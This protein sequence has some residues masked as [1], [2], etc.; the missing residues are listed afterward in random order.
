[1][2]YQPLMSTLKPVLMWWGEKK[3]V[4]QCA[5]DCFLPKKKIKIA[6]IEQKKSMWTQLI[7]FGLVILQ[8]IAKFFSVRINGLQKKKK[9]YYACFFKGP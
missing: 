9:R 1:M 8:Q 2:M 7:M 5:Q 6:F 4:N 3:V